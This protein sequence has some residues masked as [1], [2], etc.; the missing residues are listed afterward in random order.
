V[1]CEKLF[2]LKE[3]VKYKINATSQN[4]AIV[5]PC[6]NSIPYVLDLQNECENVLKVK[7][8]TDTFYFIFP[9]LISSFFTTQI[10]YQNKNLIISLS[11]KLCITLDSVLICE[12]NVD[13]LNFSHHEILGDICLLYFTGKRNFLVVINNEEILFCSYYDECNIKDYEKYF[14]CKLFDSLNHGKVCEIK[15]NKCSTYLVY[16]DDEELMLKPEFVP[17]VFLDCLKNENFKYCNHLLDENLK[18]KE[19]S[20]IKNFFPTFDFYYPLNS[21]KVVLI[22]KNTLAGIYEFSVENCLITN[23]IEC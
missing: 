5:F 6:S 11:N 21:S 20:E 12:Q 16:L 8:Q 22:N 2:K 14:M 13:N 18:M 3:S 1:F 19:S 10:K 23:I 4:Q 9:N 17:L 7:F 15:N